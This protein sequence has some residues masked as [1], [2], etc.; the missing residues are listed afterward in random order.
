MPLTRPS[1][2]RHTVPNILEF[3][4]RNS[5]WRALMTTL[6]SAKRWVRPCLRELRLGK[7]S[8]EGLWNKARKGRLVFPLPTGYVLGPDG[9][10]EFDPD[11]QVRERLGYVFEL[12]RR[13]G[14]ARRVVRDLKADA[15][16][17]PARVT[18]KEGYGTLMWKAPT[19]STVIRILQ[20]PAYAGA[21]VYGR[22]DYSGNRRSS[23]TGKHVPHL[24]PV[25]QWPVH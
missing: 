1:P 7:Q 4:Q 8:H 2:L 25:A 16:E 9:Q 24:R 23:K 5:I 20:N 17:L 12:F 15:L 18:A 10:W 14:V 11:A 22:W 13:E 3:V 19:L 21:Y 6:F